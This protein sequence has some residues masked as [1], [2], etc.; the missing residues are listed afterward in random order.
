MKYKKAARDWTQLTN[1]EKLCPGLGYFLPSG[2]EFGW[3]RAEQRFWEFG[4]RQDVVKLLYL[5]QRSQY[6]SSWA[7]FILEIYFV[8][9]DHLNYSSPLKIGRVYIK[10]CI[11]F[12][13][14][15]QIND[16]SLPFLCVTLS[17]SWQSAL[18]SWWDIP[19]LG[20][21]FSGWIPSLPYVPFWLL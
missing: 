2:L 9:S 20:I 19:S 13:N 17:W 18:P 14:N 12:L 4:G 5:T 3:R 7:E 6:E 21:T 1:N 15:Q 10:F 16:T 8:W 11:F